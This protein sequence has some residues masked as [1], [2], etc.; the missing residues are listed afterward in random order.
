M[1]TRLLER[2]EAAGVQVVRVALEVGAGTFAPLTAAAW[3]AGTLHTER[4][5]VPEGTWNAVA[6]ARSEGRP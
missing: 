5:I 6:A 2:I 4:Y 3:T 1:T